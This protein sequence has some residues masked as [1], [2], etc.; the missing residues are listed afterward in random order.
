MFRHRFRCQY[1]LFVRLLGLVK[2]GNSRDQQDR[3]VK[4]IIQFHDFL[5]HG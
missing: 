4:L 3:G 2:S 5:D 1:Q